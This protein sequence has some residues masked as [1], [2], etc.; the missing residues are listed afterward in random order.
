MVLATQII[1]KIRIL[2]V[3]GRNQKFKI[4]CKRL[5]QENRCFRL[6]IVLR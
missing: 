1:A 5:E 4:H 6:V 2:Q 3:H